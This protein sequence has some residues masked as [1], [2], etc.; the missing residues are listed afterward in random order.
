MSKVIN[1]NNIMEHRIERHTAPSSKP[2]RQRMAATV[3]DVQS[4]MSKVTFHF[5][6]ISLI[7]A[8]A[9]FFAPMTTGMQIIFAGLFI[10]SGLSCWIDEE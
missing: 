3:E 2:K 4:D 6:M 7:G 10:M 5:N 1:T 9:I 8:I